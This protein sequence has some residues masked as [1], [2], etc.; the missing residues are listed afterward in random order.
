MITVAIMVLRIAVG[1]TFLIHG[2]REAFGILGGVGP[3]QFATYLSAAGF[4]P[5]TLWAY[6]AAYVEL[7]AGVC[8]LLGFFNRTALLVL[9]LALNAAVIKVL[10]AR[11]FALSIEEYDFKLAF[12]GA[13]IA[14][15]LLDPGRKT[16]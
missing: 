2:L 15:M 11:H 16:G 5:G 8:I 6:L 14:L 3:A 9:F 10:F 4:H 13:L 1:G 7:T 12:E